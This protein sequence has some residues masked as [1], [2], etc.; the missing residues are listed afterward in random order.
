MSPAWMHPDLRRQITERYKRYAASRIESLEEYA[1][2]LSRQ[3][4]SMDSGLQTR[5]S[6]LEKLEATVADLRAEVVDMEKDTQGIHGLQDVVSNQIFCQ[7]SIASYSPSDARLSLL[8]EEGPLAGPCALE[9]HFLHLVDTCLSPTRASDEGTAKPF[10]AVHAPLF[11]WDEQTETVR[12]PFF[13][14]EPCLVE[15]SETLCQNPACSYWH[16]N[17]LRFLQSISK[18]F[19]MNAHGLRNYA[20]CSVAGALSLFALTAERCTSVDNLCRCWATLLQTV[21]SRGWHRQWAKATAWVTPV[22]A[23]RGVPPVRE[24]LLHHEHEKMAWARANSGN[25]SASAIA[26]FETE[27]TALNWRCLVRLT[28]HTPTERLWLADRGRTLFPSSPHLQVHYVL[29]H[30]DANRH[31]NPEDCI[32]VCQD[33]ARI[34]STQAAAA[35]LAQSAITYSEVAA[36]HIAF[37]IGRCVVTLAESIPSL[38]I[39]FLSFVVEPGSGICLLPTAHE[40]FTLMLIVMKQSGTLRGAADLPIA[41]LSDQLLTLSEAFP[42]KP[43]DFCGQLL[44]AQLTLINAC[45]KHVLDP[46]LLDRMKCSVHL[47]LLRAFAVGIQYVEQIIS[48]SSPH[49]EPIQGTL[50]VEYIRCVANF[51]SVEASVQV[52][53]QLLAATE[54]T[55]RSCLFTVLL[56]WHLTSHGHGDGSAV[57]SAT[58]H[59]FIAHHHLNEDEL[60]SAGYL[61]SV[62]PCVCPLE[63][64]ALFILLSQSVELP[65]QSELLLGIPVDLLVC[66]TDAAVLLLIALVRL[67]A[68]LDE[69]ELFRS[70]LHRVLYVLRQPHILHWSPIDSWYGCAV[71]V[72]HMVTLVVYRSVPTML[73]AAEERTGAWR[74]VLLE[75][76]SGLGVLHPLLQESSEE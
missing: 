75:V 59:R 64:V 21:I 63:W 5:K 13:F 69:I 18:R 4:G 41:A 60:F 26:Q 46:F 15:S 40:N 31:S 12:M 3:A 11:T 42:S 36:R 27:P 43:Q 74:Q 16:L 17:Q 44:N 37:M 9:V 51:D 53:E 35:A 10:L 24:D 45:Q 14:D 55:H 58:A 52:A 30:L 66:D 29:T 22:A 73:G 1:A 2:S 70:S 76:A 48:K 67:A 56:L 72:A 62:A 61:Q 33:A 39:S 71:G 8:A 57:A 49:S 28:G 32:N 50:W 6:R 23:L 47:S 54:P 7:K 34:L 38:V 68:A 65:H 19:V 25:P 20:M